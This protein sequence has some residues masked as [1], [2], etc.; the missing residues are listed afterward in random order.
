[1]SVRHV[2]ASDGGAKSA[3]WMQI[4]ADVLGQPVHLLEGHPGSCLG[5]AYVAGVGIGAIEGWEGIGR[6]VTPAGVI[7]PNPRTGAAYGAQYALFRE[8][9]ER[10]RP[11]YPRLVAEAGE[12]G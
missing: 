1:M 7:A 3:L 9:Y 2:V 5:A 12:G 6:F 4:A 10:L 8:T 11:L